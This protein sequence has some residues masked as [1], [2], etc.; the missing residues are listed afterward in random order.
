MSTHTV[1]PARDTAPGRI[2]KISTDDGHTFFFDHPLDHIPGMLVVDTA[3]RQAEDLAA[4]SGRGAA[5]PLRV[6]ALDL[7]FNGLCERGSDAFV[8]LAEGVPGGRALTVDVRQDGTSV[9]SGSLRLEPAARRELFAEDP[10]REGR[11]ARAPAE[12]VHKRS[13]DNVLI[14]PLTRTGEH[15]YTTVM[16]GPPAHRWPDVHPAT[17][18]V[19]AIR[20][21]ATATSHTAWDIPTDWQYILMAIRLTLSDTRTWPAAP[22][23]VC[24]ISPLKGRARGGIDIDVLVRGAQVGHMRLEARAVPPAAY[25][26]MREARNGPSRNGPSHNGSSHNGSSRNGPARTGEAAR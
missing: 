21:T 7:A 15:A 4:R 10:R 24:R 11:P 26:R 3:L 8:H 2:S 13:E 18:L 20:Q 9:C 22:E 6:R 16:L 5:E 19:E 25:R 14:G 17:V 1:N 12:L 23:L